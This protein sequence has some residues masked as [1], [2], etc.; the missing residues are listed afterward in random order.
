MAA[1]H[2]AAE[3]LL[4]LLS[5]PNPARWPDFAGSR[6]CLSLPADCWTVP[7]LAVRQ[8]AVV[9]QHQSSGSAEINSMSTEGSVLSSDFLLFYAPRGVSSTFSPSPFRDARERQ[10]C[11]PAGGSSSVRYALPG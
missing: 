3:F 6:L 9:E 11:R 1:H 8:A 7:G 4:D 5:W 10:L 2:G